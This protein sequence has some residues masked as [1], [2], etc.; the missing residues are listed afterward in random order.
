ML[1][2]GCGSRGCVRSPALHRRLGRADLRIGFRRAGIEKFERHISTSWSGDTSRSFS[3]FHVCIL[4]LFFLDHRDE[5]RHKMYHLS[6]EFETVAH[7]SAGSESF[8]SLYTVTLHKDQSTH[9]G[10]IRRRTRKQCRQLCR[11]R[12]A[13]AACRPRPPH[14]RFVIR[15]PPP[16]RTCHGSL[17]RLLL[18]RM[19][20]C[21]ARAVAAIAVLGTP[22][23][24]MAR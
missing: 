4:H 5:K 24:S 8:S 15:A 23:Q 10:L 2:F 16:L 6:T 13:S 1:L 22:L 12:A 3:T 7:D 20:I 18:C 9:D 21:R 17:L 19:M 11:A 14:C